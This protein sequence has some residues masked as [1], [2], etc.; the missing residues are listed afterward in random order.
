MPSALYG[1]H[2]DDP[3][4]VITAECD[5]RQVAATES[6]GRKHA[7]ANRRA[8]MAPHQ[9]WPLRL[10]PEPVR[11]A[12]RSQL[13]A[14]RGKRRIAETRVQQSHQLCSRPDSSAQLRMHHR[15]ARALRKVR[16]VRSKQAVHLHKKTKKKIVIHITALTANQIWLL[17]S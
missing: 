16:D 7:A 9:R 10:G 15:S 1:T 11:A 8:N 14:Q 4:N 5:A 2:R 17:I 6:H 12:P 3:S 13:S